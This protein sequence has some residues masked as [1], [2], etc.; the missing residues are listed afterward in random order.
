MTRS[1]KESDRAQA[2][3][4]SNFKC[5]QCG[6]DINYDD[7]HAD[8]I[9]PYSK[10]GATDSGNIQALCASCN[11]QKSD[12]TNLRKH[13]QDIYNLTRKMVNRL[14]SCKNVFLDVTPG[15]GKSSVPQIAG[16]VLKQAGLIDKICWVV[17]RASLQNQG[18]VDFVKDNKYS[19]RQLIGHNLTINEAGNVFDPSRGTDGYATTYQAISRDS[20]GRH[21]SDFHKYKYAIFLDEAQFLSSAEDKTFRKNILPLVEQAKYVFLMSGTPERGDG[22]PIAFLPYRNISDKKQMIDRNHVDWEYITYSRTDALKEEALIPLIFRKLDASAAWLD[23]DGNKIS[24]TSLNE[25]GEESRHGL[26]TA[27]KTD[28]AY[29][30]LDECLKS[31]QTRKEENPFS[32][33]LVVA[34]N[35]KT[36]KEYLNHIVDKY[37]NVLV[38]WATTDDE[39]GMKNNEAHENIK[40][41]RV[42]EIDILVTVGMA[43]VGLDA[44]SVD[45]I[46][47]LTNIRS[48]PY[49]EQMFAR[50]TRVDYDLLKM[51]PAYQQIAIVYVPD[52]A[53]VNEVIDKIQAEQEEAIG[54]P[55]DTPPP[56]PPPP[57]P[58]AETITPLESEFTRESGY[59]LSTDDEI[60]Y[61]QTQKIKDI[62]DK[63][64]IPA[65]PIL[66]K[67]FL[68][69]A[70]IEMSN[71]ETIVM[72]IQQEQ[73]R[74]NIITPKE[75]TTAL[76][77]QIH[78]ASNKYAYRNG[79][80]YDVMNRQI[81]QHFGKSRTL[82][83]PDELRE[84]AAYIAGLS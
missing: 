20:A 35:I 45:H 2:L 24:I 69:I 19:M 8:H 64:G 65:A 33:M 72:P 57:P 59:D 66:L 77:R 76:L 61:I 48:A 83:T 81:K 71:S 52:D 17:P 37:P 42:R 25:A 84:V 49:L 29:A 55:D 80:E 34:S 39:N 15:G 4:D 50:A 63:L 7:Y 21:L 62:A 28:Y 9:F 41:F 68:D 23:T 1:F 67:K 53:M 32:Q 60:D 11:I 51:N 75:E 74:S 40:K 56:P 78:K 44:P 22:K 31:W 79:I 58:P 12:K 13:Q 82:M 10:G 73:Y 6:C 3:T 16:H 54:V 70:G 43:Y 26:M 30:L 27:L 5:Q 18:A 47:V 46:A 14:T 38:K 36:A